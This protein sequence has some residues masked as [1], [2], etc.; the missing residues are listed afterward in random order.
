MY[1]MFILCCCAQTSAQDFPYSFLT[2]G[3]YTTSSKLFHHTTDTDPTVRAEFLPIDNIVGGGVEIIRSF[4]SLQL[5][6]G[7]N[8]EF[9]KRMKMTSEWNGQSSK[10]NVK[11]GYYVIPIEL[12]GYFF[13]PFDLQRIRLF[14]GGGGGIYLGGRSYSYDNISSKIV[15]Q[16]PGAG[17]HVLCG[18]DIR[19][20]SRMFLR[21]SVK[22]RDINFQSVNRWIDG[23]MNEELHSRVNVDGMTVTL[24]I[25]FQL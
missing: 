18:A 9:M 21:S 1:L 24:G 15:R 6:I 14:M 10:V 23:T 12:T 5:Q 4:Q 11:N 19:L 13:L 8:I 16:A 3:S 17:I 2:F 20:S 7:V 22:F 25:L